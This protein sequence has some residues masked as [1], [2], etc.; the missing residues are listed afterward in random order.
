MQMG[1][2]PEHP[3]GKVASGIGGIMLLPG[4]GMTQTFF[5]GK[6]ILPKCGDTNTQDQEE[7]HNKHPE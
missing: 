6:R 4:K 5:R 1:I 3:T 7:R 2:A